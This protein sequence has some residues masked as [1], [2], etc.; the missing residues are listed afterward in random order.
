MAE[1]EITK[2]DISRLMR[3]VSHQRPIVAGTCEICGKP[4]EGLSTRRYC[5]NKCAARASR[6]ARA[7]TKS[8]AAN[9]S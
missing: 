1:D 7:E 6:A 3:Y 4:F 8:S 2:E 5:S 9:K